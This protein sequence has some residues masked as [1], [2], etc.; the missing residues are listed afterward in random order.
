VIDDADLFFPDLTPFANRRVEHDEAGRGSRAGRGQLT[1]Y[2][3][4]K[5]ARCGKI[6]ANGPCH[7]I[8]LSDE[9]YFFPDDMVLILMKA[10]PDE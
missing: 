4:D 5:D 2:Q 7:G 3:Q 6:F 9:G 1:G 8:S 10:G